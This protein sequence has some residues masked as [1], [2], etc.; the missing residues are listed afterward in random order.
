[1]GILNTI[2]ESSF[3]NLPMVKEAI[4]DVLSSLI[5]DEITTIHT[6]EIIT[7]LYDRLAG[8]CVKLAVQSLEV[9]GKGSPPVAFSWYQMGSGARGEQFML[10]DQDHFIVYGDLADKQK[11]NWPMTT[12]RNLEKKL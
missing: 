5:Q 9:Q 11:K 6:L 3:D 2:E 4:Y 10:T 7:K 8:H 1:M 12:L